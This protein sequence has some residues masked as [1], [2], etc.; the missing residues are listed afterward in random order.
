M[1]NE[2]NIKELISKY[3]DGEAAPEEI[4]IVEQAIKG[5]ASLRKYYEEL[6][7][8]QAALKSWDEEDLSPDLEQKLY[9]ALP[10]KPL[11]GE[12]KMQLTRRYF[13]QLSTLLVLVMVLVVSMQVYV[14]RG[15]Q[16]H[17]KSATDDIGEQFSPGNTSVI[18]KVAEKVAQL[19]PSRALQARVRDASQYLAKESGQSQGAV[20]Y[21]PY[22]LKT[23]YLV[24]RDESNIALQSPQAQSAPASAVRAFG[25][26]QESTYDAGLLAGSMG[27]EKEIARYRVDADGRYCDSIRCQRAPGNTEEYQRIY[28]NEFLEVAANPLSTLSIDVDTA[29][30]ANVRRYLM[31]WNQMPPADAVRIE[32][33]INYFDY[34]YPAPK[35]EHPFSVTIDAAQC[36][37]NSK[38]QLAR[39]GIQGKTL[40]STEVPPS[41]LVFLIDVS[42]SM[43]EP[44]KLPLLKTSFKKMVNQLSSNENVAIVVYAGNAGLVLDSTPGS[45]K[46]AILDAIDRLEAGG[47]TAGGAGIQLAYQIAKDHFIKGGNNRVILA[48]DGDFNVGVSSTSE[49][50]RLIEEKRKDGIFLTVLGFGTGNYKDGRMEQI[51][52]KGNGNF[53]Y[54]DTEKEGQKVL[55]DELGSTIF[56][57]AKDVKIQIEFNPAQVK[58]YRLI[59]YENRVL[60]KEDFNDDTKDAGELGAG[61]TVTALYELVPTDSKEEFRKTDP[62][63]YQKGQE[64]KSKDLMTVKLRYKK[65]DE[66]V[67]KLIQTSVTSDEITAEPKGDFQFAAAVAE[68]GLI[69]RNS[70]FKGSSSYEQILQHAQEATGEDKYGYRAEFVDLVK[71]AQSLDSRAPTPIPLEEDSSSPAEPQKGE[72]VIFFKGL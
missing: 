49:M 57:I 2:L 31:Q 67:S 43:N 50:I 64:V 32:E 52:D 23:N 3:I 62:L 35:G 5:D 19:N 9:N 46:H 28:E 40:Q 65:P 29:A 10:G 6:K 11:K 33:M 25:G 69:L 15:I 59:G 30:Y 54:I 18:H 42:G 45:N 68:F 14:K 8:V 37:W 17:F 13:T 38:H 66:D 4:Q 21:E 20:Q 36:P 71:K 55:V 16:G 34:K 53:Y 26:F 7:Q 61:H 70:Q 39:I 60:A 41:N 1:N 12:E 22:Y 58:A 51:A 27:E 44:N 72:S 47:S 24:T 56:T 63:V 48:T